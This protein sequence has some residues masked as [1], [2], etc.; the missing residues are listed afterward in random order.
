MSTV[1][2]AKTTVD[3]PNAST[4]RANSRRR[5][6]PTV[7]SLDN[8]SRTTAGAGTADNQRPDQGRKGLPDAPREG[9]EQGKGSPDRQ[10]DRRQLAQQGRPQGRQERLLRRLEQAGPDATGQRD[11]HQGPVDDEQAA[12]D[13]GATGSLIRPGRQ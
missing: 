4:K 12:A 9:R 13:Q 1:P 5:R 10:R 7:K 3:S 6:S 8:S 2:T 11:R